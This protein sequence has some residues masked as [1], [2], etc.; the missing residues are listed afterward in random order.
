MEPS[1]SFLAPS[2]TP[3]RG[4][5][6]VPRM[7]S[8]CELKSIACF[9]I[10]NNRKENHTSKLYIIPI[11]TVA[12]F[13]ASRAS[14]ESLQFGETSR[15]TNANENQRINEFER[16]LNELFDEVKRMIRV[17]KKDDAVDL[18][19]AN[20][21]VVK[22][23]MNA[24]AKGIEE[25][26]LLDVIALGYVAVGDIKTIGSLL[27]VMKE[28]IDNLKD[29]SPHLDLIL[30]HMGSMYST[31]SKFGKSLDTYQRAF[32]I[33]ERTYGKDSPFLVTPYLA[34]AKV[35]G[36]TGKATK[37]IEKYQCAITI[38]ESK[39]GAESKD[40]V[41]PLLGLGN[42]LLKER[43]VNDAET[44]FTRVLD[45][46]TKSY[47]QNDGRIGL[48][49]TSLAQV[50]CAQGKPDE[51]IHL[52]ERAL[53][54]MNDSNYLSPDDSIMEKMRVDLA[55]LL[56]AVGRAQEGR[57]LLEECLLITERHKGKGHLSLVTHM[58]NLATSYS[59]SK[60]YAEAEH[61]LRRSLEIMIKQKGSDDP[62]VSFPMLQL[63][64]TLYHLKQDEE[65]EKLA[66]DALR[67]REKTFGED[68]LPVGEALDCLVSIQ[69]RVGKD[70]SEL[71]V[72]LRRI[73]DIQEKEFGYE[74][75]EVL[76]TLKKIVSFL[77]KL[78]RS[79][80]MLPLQR[81]LSLLRKK[82]KQMIYH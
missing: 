73:L 46:Y 67:I 54:V 37:A 43:R 15:R 8:V 52:Y 66:L 27:N 14:L 7:F 78:G 76:V 49:M 28:V 82:Y 5:K 74:S 65:A 42:L 59:Q 60:N 64:V 22:D 63:A 25:A 71:L 17:G 35:L 23:R 80:E 16:E 48:A 13:C 29:D 21:E 68:S 40:L 57:E 3:C 56:H 39:R 33:M 53:H 61:L 55:E 51:A 36:S 77:D 44:H 70:E 2:F 38:L 34:M 24:G 41:V 50:K 45:I 20:Y 75:E 69:T 18:L 72:L 79:D 62:S 10:S 1:A 32:N 9:P 4:S 58:I 19:N 26:A 81:R 31:L 11:K 12:R 30:M 6:E 47:G